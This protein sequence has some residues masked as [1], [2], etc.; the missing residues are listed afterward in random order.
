ME[1]S[2]GEHRRASRTSL[3]GGALSLLCAI[4]CLLLPILL[5]FAST[6]AHSF[7]L[8]AVLLAAAVAV[9]ARAL[10]HGFGRHGFR[11]PACLFVVAVAAIAVGNWA[12]GP[13][14]GA[15]VESTALLVLGG[16]GIVAAHV[17]NFVLE[18]R[19]IAQENSSRSGPS[20]SGESPNIS[21]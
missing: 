7:W 5:P 8:E 15:R 17:L 19:W 2:C 10:K 13:D 9:G 14:H 4:H 16:V 1:H 21:A 3:I 11:L 12:F 18:R 6:I 20:F